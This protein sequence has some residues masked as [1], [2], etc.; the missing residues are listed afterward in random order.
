VAK[1]KSSSFTKLTTLIWF[2]LFFSFFKAQVEIKPSQILNQS[3]KKIGPKFLFKKII[4]EKFD[5][6]LEAILLLMSHEE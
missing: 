5:E 2:K 4:L 3:S 1:G 6:V